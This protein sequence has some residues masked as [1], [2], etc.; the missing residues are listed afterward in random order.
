MGDCA[1]VE[2]SLP[3]V[4]VEFGHDK[5]V[6][7]WKDNR[8]LKKGVLS[9]EVPNSTSWTLYEVKVVKGYGLYDDAHQKLVRLEKEAETSAAEEMDKSRTKVPP[10]R[11][12]R[13]SQTKIKNKSS[14]EEGEDADMESDSDDGYPKLVLVDANRRQISAAKN[15]V[16]SPQNS[17]VRSV[18]EDRRVNTPSSSQTVSIGRARL[19]DY[20]DSTLTHAQPTETFEKQMIRKVDFLTASV[21]QTNQ[22]NFPITNLDDWKALEEDLKLG[23]RNV[24]VGDKHMRVSEIKDALVQ[25]LSFVGGRRTSEAAYRVMA[26]LMTDVMMTTFS[27]VGKTGKH[28]ICNYPE[29]HSSILRAVRLIIPA[30]SSKDTDEAIKYYLKKAPGRIAAQNKKP[31]RDVPS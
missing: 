14:D 28:A 30:S 6:G 10:K 23:E 7:I 22:F 25:D 5:S 17:S 8:K 24:Q 2:F 1:L 20:D 31:V 15:D 27:F 11:K 26:E 16:T 3:F 18:N 21:I 19:I 12:R 4:V 29:I 9:G 13:I